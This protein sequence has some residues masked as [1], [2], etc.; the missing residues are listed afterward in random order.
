MSGEGHLSRG[1]C[2]DTSRYVCVV[3]EFLTNMWTI[4][5]DVDAN[6]LKLAISRRVYA[7]DKTP[8]RQNP[9]YKIKHWMTLNISYSNSSVYII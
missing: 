9:L 8:L 6:I 5:V 4:F 7:Y 2:P 3:L 1:A